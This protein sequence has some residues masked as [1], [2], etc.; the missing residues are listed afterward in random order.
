MKLGVWAKTKIMNDP[1]LGLAMANEIVKHEMA[2]RRRRKAA[3]EK[4]IR[5]IAE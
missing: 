4:K 1:D 5:L 2:L 3:Q